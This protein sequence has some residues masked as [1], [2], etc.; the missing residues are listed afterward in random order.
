MCGFWKVSGKVATP[1]G[2]CGTDDRAWG[3]G[4]RAWGR[5]ARSRWEQGG[6]GASGVRW[7]WEIANALLRDA[8]CDDAMMPNALTSGIKSWLRAIIFG[9]TG[10]LW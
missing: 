7:R 5:G 3:M 8:E 9:K 10:Q 6:R 4:H 1:L 2:R